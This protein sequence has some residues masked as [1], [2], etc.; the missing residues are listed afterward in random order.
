MKMNGKVYQGDGVAPVVPKNLTK[1]EKQGIA[2]FWARRK[3]PTAA[4]MRAARLARWEAQ[5]KNK[6]HDAGR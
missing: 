3:V 6:E 4:Q 2:D 1:S 5:R